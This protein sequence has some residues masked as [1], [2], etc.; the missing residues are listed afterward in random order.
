M[1]LLLRISNSFDHF[2]WI[3]FV[4]LVI[5]L[6]LGAC[7]PGE[8]TNSNDDNSMPKFELE[9]NSMINIYDAFGEDSELAK[10]LEKVDETTKEF[11]NL[12]SLDVD[13]LDG[14]TVFKG[15]KADSM[16]MNYRKN[17][18]TISADSFKL[19]V[20]VFY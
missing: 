2:V 11:S 8:K 13:N 14:I 5:F 6:S 16:M 7:S 3:H 18:N 17:N 20:V 15:K 4:I 1:S 19:Q 10:F 9:E 12:D